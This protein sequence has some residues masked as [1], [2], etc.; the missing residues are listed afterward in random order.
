MPISQDY[1]AIFFH[2]PKTAG[3]AVES[4]LN[5]RYNRQRARIDLLNHENKSPDSPAY[6]HFLP[7]RTRQLLQEDGRAHLWDDFYK[8]TVVRHPCDRMASV[9]HQLDRCRRFTGHPERSFIEF[10]QFAVS[11]VREKEG[12]PEFYD[13]EPHM[14]H[15]R[16]QHHWFTPENDVYNDVFRYE[17][18]NA[19]GGG[20]DR[21]CRTLGCQRQL[22]RVNV[23]PATDKKVDKAHEVH[24]THGSHGTHGTHD[25]GREGER[26]QNKNDGCSAGRYRQYYD[27]N[28]V[29]LLERGYGKD[30]RLG[31][32]AYEFPNV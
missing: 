8:F 3:S 10:L 18:L 13:R 24:G 28:A 20:V 26:V 7:S 25:E 5:I 14:H 11:V 12:D 1:S 15:L 22:P 27:K 16:P 31:S 6:Q 4:L 21:L 29:L 2:I 19:E 30:F 9:Y 17:D 32:L 23:T